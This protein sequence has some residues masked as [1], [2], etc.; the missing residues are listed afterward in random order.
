MITLLLFA[1]I[2]LLLALGICG[3][4]RDPGERSLRDIPG[5]SALP[6]IGNLAEFTHRRL[7]IR[8]SELA[9][10]FGPIYRLR[11]WGQDIIVLN[12]LDV[13]KEALVKRS[14]AFAGRPKSFVGDFVSF[15]GKDLSLGDYTHAWKVQKK[16]AHSAM[17]WSRKS[18]L[19]PVVMR[20]AERLCEYERCDPQLQ[21]IH[22]CLTE[23]VALWGSC[24]IGLIDMFP[25]LQYIPNS[26]WRDLQKALLK[27]NAFV[28]Q[29]IQNHKVSQSNKRK[30][31]TF[32]KGVTRDITDMLMRTIWD[33][34]EGSLEQGEVTEEH[35]HMIIVDL[36]IGGM[37]TTSS[38]L[39]WAIAYLVHWPE[40][41]DQI[42][43]EICSRVG[44]DRYPEYA[45]HKKLPLLMATIAEVLRL[46]PV[47]PLSLPHQTTSNSSVAGYFIPS[48][49]HVITNLFES[50]YDESKWSEPTHFRPD[51][52]L[53]VPEAEKAIQ[54]VISFGMGPRSCLGEPFAR[55]ELFLFL[56]YLL[57]DFKFLPEESGI[58]PNLQCMESKLMRIKHYRVTIVR[59]SNLKHD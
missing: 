26:A 13:I 30:S 12:S 44:E 34:K 50:N 27:R 52:F 3:N 15:G 22:D 8:L 1:A 38:T 24:A 23:L 37:E 20:E 35:I 2:A 43:Q 18:A 19:E 29:H 40:I 49:T 47:V 45:D 46:R 41:Q 28:R 16:L 7:H 58:L 9:K 53:D 59:R 54:N 51:R 55:I 32:Q 14:S 4:R 42:Y 56:A 57:K 21:E 39:G 33:L 36:F 25:V 17:H 11:L 31:V 5:P 10:T 48:G 6:L